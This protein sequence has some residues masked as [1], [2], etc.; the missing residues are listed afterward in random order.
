M[1]AVGGRGACAAAARGGVTVVVVDG[2]TTE[3]G[4]LGA[5]TGAA[6]AGGIVLTTDVDA[7]AL[8]APRVAAAGTVVDRAAAVGPE[9]IAGGTGGLEGPGDPGDPGD[10]DGDVRMASGGGTEVVTGG[11]FDA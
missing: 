5:R 6:T 3:G 11:S 10:N 9:N 2:A 7:A 1:V 4:P 8:G